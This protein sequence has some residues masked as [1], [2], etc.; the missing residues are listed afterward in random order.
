MVRMAPRQSNNPKRRLIAA[1]SVNA[2][3]LLVLANSVAYTGSALHKRSPGNYNFSPPTNPRPSKSLCDGKRALL[4]EEAAN[5]LRTG[6][7]N[8]FVSFFS[9][10]TFPKY[11]WCVDACGDVYEAKFDN[12]GYHGYRLE[13]TDD[14]RL[15]I[16][17]EWAQRCRQP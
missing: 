14:F 3:R 4:R 12:L 9:D 11:V 13:E 6:I 7:L 2:E 16:K 5:L 8:G 15:Y 1:N 10:N 17:E